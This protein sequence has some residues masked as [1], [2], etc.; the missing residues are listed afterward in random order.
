MHYKIEYTSTDT[1]IIVVTFQNNDCNSSGFP[2]LVS[3]KIQNLLSRK[4]VV[5]YS[6]ANLSTK[7]SHLILPS[8]VSLEPGLHNYMPFYAGRDLNKVWR[9]FYYYSPATYVDFKGRLQHEDKRTQLC[10]FFLI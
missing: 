7:T 4:H 6:E 1:F 8:L 3:N 2:F 10:F 9:N 5:S